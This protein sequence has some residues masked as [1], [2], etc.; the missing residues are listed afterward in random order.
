MG[1]PGSPGYNPGAVNETPPMQQKVNDQKFL[2]KAAEGGMAE[3][4]MGKLAEQKG[5]TEAVKQFGQKLVNDHTKANDQL[6]EVAAKENLEV[7]SALSKKHQKQVDKLAK[8]SGPKFD[9][10]FIHHAVKDHK[11]DIEEF[12]A[13]AQHGSNPTV[14]QFASNSVPVLQEHLNIAENLQ[15]SNG[16]SSMKGA[17]G[18][19]G[20]NGGMQDQGSQ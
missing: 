15:K 10:A 20:Q 8:L 18:M 17:H 16:Q 5:S 4:A 11:K 9:K 7:P 19:N 13:E 12:K 6:K 14:R 3:I 2:K 1:Q